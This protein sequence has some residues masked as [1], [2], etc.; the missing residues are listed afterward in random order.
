[1]SIGDISVLS[2][3]NLNLAYKSSQD[4]KTCF[5]EIKKHQVHYVDR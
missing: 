3:G 1:M 2:T 5:S 4:S